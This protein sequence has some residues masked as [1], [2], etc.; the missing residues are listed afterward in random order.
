MTE[1]TWKNEKSMGFIAM[2]WIWI[3]YRDGQIRKEKQKSS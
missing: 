2:R 3:L 1:M